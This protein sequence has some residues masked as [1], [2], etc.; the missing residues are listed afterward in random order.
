MDF[1]KTAKAYILYRHERA[2]IRDKQKLVPERVKRL[3]QESKK[4]FQN[5]LAEF[6]TTELILDGLKKKAGGKP[7][8]RL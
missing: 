8:S 3:V 7:G 4:Y 1:P 5:A 2:R 6:I